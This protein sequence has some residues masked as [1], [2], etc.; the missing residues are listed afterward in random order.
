MMRNNFYM[1]PPVIKDLSPITTY[2]IY[3]NCYW[4]SKKNG[5]FIA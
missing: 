5:E 1:K 2:Q 3:R 4:E